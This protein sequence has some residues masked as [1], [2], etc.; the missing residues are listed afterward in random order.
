VPSA[1]TVALFALLACVEVAWA[2]SAPRLVRDITPAVE[3]TAGSNPVGGVATADRLLFAAQDGLHGV[4]PWVTD[5]TPDGTR[6]LR[7]VLPG[8]GGSFP[9]SLAGTPDRVG[10]TADD[11]ASGRELWL[12]DLTEAGT[13]RADEVQPGVLGSGPG[14]LTWVGDR[15]VMLATESEVHGLW[16]TDASGAATELVPDLEP[17]RR[18]CSRLSGPWHGSRDYDLVPSGG[19]AYLSW[20]RQPGAGIWVTDGTRGGTARLADLVPA[21]GSSS[22]W[23]LTPWRGRLAFVREATAL[24]EELWATDGTAAGTNRLHAAWLGAVGA[25]GSFVYFYSHDDHQV[26]RTDGTAAGTIPL[27]RHEPG[28][29]WSPFE[30]VALGDRVFF[31]F[32]D[33]DTGRELWV[34]DGTPEAT[35]LVSDLT[36]GPAS[37]DPTD[38]MAAGGRVYF[39]SGA[40]GGFHSSDGTGSG[41]RLL[42]ASRPWNG[43]EGKAI[44]VGGRVAFIAHDGIVGDELWI[45]DGTPAGTTVVRDVQPAG[46]RWAPDVIGVLGDLVVF[47]ADDGV[48][49]REPWITDGTPEGT[50]LLLDVNVQ[51]TTA[52]PAQLTAVGPRAYFVADDSVHGPEPWVTDGTAAGTTLLEDIAPGV[53]GSSPTDLT[54]VGDRLVFTAADALG[55]E[56]WVNASAMGGATRLGD[57]APGPADGVRRSWGA[58]HGLA[59]LEG[60]VVSPLGTRTWVSDGT[61]AGTRRITELALDA[62]SRV[63]AHGQD[64]ALWGPNGVTIADARA[65]RATV[66]SPP[67]Q[68]GHEWP[69]TVASTGS[70]AWFLAYDRAA[71]SEPWRSDGTPGSATRVHDVRAGPCW[72]FARD[73][74]PVGGRLFFTAIED[75]TGRELWVA[76]AS[77]ARL[78]Q[79]LVPGTGD[80]LPEAGELAAIGSRLVFTATDGTTG[81]EPWITDG[82]AAGTRLLADIAPA[83]LGSS[84]EGY[85][86][87]TPAG[88]L[89]FAADD[90]LHGM[91]LWWSDGTA[92]GTRLVADVAPGRRPSNP[93]EMVVAGATLFWVADDG[94]AGPEPWALDLPLAG[95]VPDGAGVPGQ[96]L[97]VSRISGDGVRL[98]WD[99]SC[100]RRDAG[101]A[102]YEGALGDYTTHVPATCSVDGVTSWYLRPGPSSRYFVVSALGGNGIEGPLGVASDGTPRAPGP[103]PCGTPTPAA[104]RP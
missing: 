43:D 54:Q 57:L 79:D 71:G 40:A 77:G 62:H 46:T 68:Q 9:R 19:R 5:G 39:W 90:G 104:C 73:L 12:S 100:T 48:H 56:P 29:G 11:G 17:G 28:C 72:S 69:L 97:R 80:A 42:T 2:Q 99:A 51:S 91:E 23:R 103:A 101:Y 32:Q 45:S 74:T 1:R 76:D 75:A 6:L 83:G 16:A 47:A 98:D 34:S 85:V 38:L 82:T 87:V 67:D 8:P 14:L 37:T 70:H 20:D 86:Q 41:T 63:T 95:E 81:L 89:V 65:Q 50:R 21:L 61:S 27:A 93:R 44:A 84:P 10:F 102:V 36:P 49:G 66:V 18:E 92:A 52:P 26:W 35:R 58:A 78:V 88:E 22:T 59:W 3:A 15:V 55:R 64:V 24:T 25:A 33:C 94:V 31:D 13:R 96:P 4:E 60:Q 30:L 53:T 7:D